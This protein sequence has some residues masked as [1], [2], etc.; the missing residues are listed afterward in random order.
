VRSAVF[1]RLGSRPVWAPEFY[2]DETRSGGV[3]TD[4]HIHDTDFIVHCF[5]VPA[6]VTS[7]GD[8]MHLS[9]IYHYADGPIHV[10]AHAAW[11]QQPSVGFRMQCTIIC[12]RATIEFDIAQENQ[13]ILYEGDDSTPINV[14][15]LNGYDGEIRAML[16]AIAGDRSRLW[17]NMDDALCVAKVLDHERQSMLARSTIKVLSD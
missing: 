4:L 10:M 2:G 6:S 5:G 15:D 16:D 13:M 1:H 7:S 3:L 11:D 8:A 9:T 17:A 12:Q 14:G